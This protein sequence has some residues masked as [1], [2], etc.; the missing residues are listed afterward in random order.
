MKKDGEGQTDVNYLG[1]W[2]TKEDADKGLASLQSLLGK[3]GNEIGQLKDGMSKISSQMAPQTPAA[4]DAP[5]KNAEYIAEMEGIDSDVKKL[6]P[7]EDGYAE[8]LATLMKRSNTLSAKMQ[9]EKTL[10]AA[11]EL[12]QEEL[13]N[14]DNKAVQTAFFDANPD[15]QTPEMQVKIDEKIAEDKTGLLDP[16]A[17]YWAIK[18]DESQAKAADLAAENEELKKLSEITD[19]ANKTTKIITGPGSGAAQT[20]AGKTKKTGAELTQGMLEAVKAAT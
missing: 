17:A 12:F 14:R 10:A 9:H 8:N 18:S 19:G 2:K 11:S 4:P 16:L 1:D 15:F 3:Q 7:L 20:A 5:D 13:D 6:D